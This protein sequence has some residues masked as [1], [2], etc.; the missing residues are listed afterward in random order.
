MSSS[1]DHPSLFAAIT[2]FV[3]DDHALAGVAHA[4]ALVRLRRAVG[5]N[6]RRDLADLLLVDAL[7]D[8]FGLQRRLDLDAFR[9]LVHDRVREAQRQIE[10]VARGLRAVTDADQRELLLRS[11]R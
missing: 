1:P 3:L 10:L 7:D 9:H 4:L 2:F 6:L 8:D 11:R 5:A